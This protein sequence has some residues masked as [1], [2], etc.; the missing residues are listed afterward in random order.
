MQILFILI[1]V[2]LV[3][4]LITKQ[5]SYGYH[6]EDQIIDITLSLYL[7]EDVICQQFECVITEIKNILEC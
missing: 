4:Q 3:G 2:I 7:L 6:L 1:S 5:V